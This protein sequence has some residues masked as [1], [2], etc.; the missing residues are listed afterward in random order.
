MHSCTAYLHLLACS[1][2][3]SYRLSPKRTC[4]GV[5]DVGGVAVRK[6]CSSLPAVRFLPVTPP[7]ISTSRLARLSLRRSGHNTTT[8]SPPARRKSM[9]SALYPRRRNTSHA[10]KHSTITPQTTAATDQAKEGSLSPVGLRC[11]DAIQ[12]QSVSSG[13]YLTVHKGW[14]LGW[15]SEDYQPSASSKHNRNAAKVT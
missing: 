1:R 2:N 14:W 11:G 7:H 8:A 6:E 10:E 13:R 4:F 5:A 9:L 3:T 12:L 15:T